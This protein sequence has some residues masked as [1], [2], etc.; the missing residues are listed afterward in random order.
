MEGEK[1][2][3][4]PEGYVYLFDK[5]FKDCDSYLLV[6]SWENGYKLFDSEGNKVD[7]KY[8]IYG[9]TTSYN[10]GFSTEEYDE[11]YEEY[12]EEDYEE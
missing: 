8:D 10:W 11:E 7:T 1:V 9:Y 3:D 6:G 5:E 12:E 2:A 4:L